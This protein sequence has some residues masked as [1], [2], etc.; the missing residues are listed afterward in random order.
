VSLA[1]PL[2]GVLRAADTVAM[3]YK[4]PLL[5]IP[6]LCALFWNQAVDADSYRCGRKLVRTG[7]STSELLR[8]CGE[9]KMRDRGRAEIRVGGRRE[10]TKVERWHYRQGSRRLGR[11]VLVHQGRIVGI[12]VSGR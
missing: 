2:H 12:E 5:A 9:P 4:S 11:V 6:L 7:D 1:L 3:K 10:T 8:K